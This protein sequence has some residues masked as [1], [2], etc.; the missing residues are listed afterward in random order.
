MAVS[1]TTSSAQHWNIELERCPVE[2]LEELIALLQRIKG[3]TEIRLSLRE[4]SGQLRQ[5][6]RRFF[7]TSAN[8]AD[9]QRR[10]IFVQPN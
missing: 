1:G 4:V 10:Y 5:I 9:L 2:Q 8:A 3:D 7:T 6:E